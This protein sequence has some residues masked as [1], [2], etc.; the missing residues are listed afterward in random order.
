MKLNEAISGVTMLLSFSLLAQNQIAQD[1]RASNK[2]IIKH[3]STALIKVQNNNFVERPWGGF[4][5]GE[6]KQL[7]A[8]NRRIGESFELSAFNG[9]KET[10]EHPSMVVFSDGS[11]MRLVDLLDFAGYS[12]LGLPF[13]KKY[14]RQ[15]PLLPKTLN[16]TQLLSLQAHPQGNVE[17]YIIID[18]DPSATL[19]L[20]FK[21]GVN[22]QLLKKTAAHGRALQESLLTFVRRDA[23]QVKFYD[24]ISD[25]FSNRKASIDLLVTMLESYF[26]PGYDKSAVKKNLANL[27]NIYWF[28]LDQ[29]NEIVVQPGQVIHNANPQRFLDG[30]LPSA[31]VHALGNE[32]HYEIVALEIRRPGV[33]YRLWDN[34]RFPLRSIDIDASL[35]A[36]NSKGTSP[37]EFIVK[38]HLLR[39]GIERL[40]DCHAYSIER[41]TV[42]KGQAIKQNADRNPHILIAIEGTIDFVGGTG[43]PIGSLSRGES[44]LMPV[45]VKDY[46]CTTKDKKA[47]LIKVW[48]PL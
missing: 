22:S 5:L 9:D 28:M 2:D 15:M 11:S 35:R 31:E 25:H 3:V 47:V 26:I 12:I 46:L 13:V 43:Q 30:E 18:A 41:L 27:K 33:T 1:I 48:L 38:P 21:N 36:L 19:R 17:T 40:V 8:D 42:E 4:S 20:G 37:D 32:K 10:Q 34:A 29:L 45:R 16:I 23:N 6:Y 24:M 14:G 39:K 44:G 7:N